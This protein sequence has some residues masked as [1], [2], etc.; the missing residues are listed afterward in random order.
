MTSSRVSPTTFRRRFH[1]QPQVLA[2]TPLVGLLAGALL[3]ACDGGDSD[4][5]ATGTPTVEATSTAGAG[6][7]GAFAAQ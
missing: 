6:D 7:S 1:V 4:A 2:A 5:T 3:V